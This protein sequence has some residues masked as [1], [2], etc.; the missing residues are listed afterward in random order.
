MTDKTK[1]A[2]IEW[3]TKWTYEFLSEG[4]LPY[5]NEFVEDKTC[6]FLLLKW[7]EL[8]QKRENHRRSSIEV[9]IYMKLNLK[10]EF[11]LY[12][13]E[14]SYMFQSMLNLQSLLR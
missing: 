4:I 8:H 12:K 3:C 9:A 14:S 2:L 5:V 7:Y 1:Q 6:E 13:E 11:E 10:G